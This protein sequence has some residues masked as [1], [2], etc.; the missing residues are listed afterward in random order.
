MQELKIEK[1][2]ESDYRTFLFHCALLLV[3]AASFYVSVML[4]DMR[5]KEG[6]YL[7]WTILGQAQ[8]V[9]SFFA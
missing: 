2:S 1:V 3:L 8:L 9:I 6:G 4:L 7:F 5:D